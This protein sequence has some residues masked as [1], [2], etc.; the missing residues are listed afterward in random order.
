MHLAPIKGGGHG[1]LVP[2]VGELASLTSCTAVSTLLLMLT[3]P[4]ALGPGPLPSRKETVSPSL[5]LALSSGSCP[6]F[7][8]L[9]HSSLLNP[10]SHL[11]SDLK[12]PLWGL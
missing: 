1:P 3:S 9:P 11:G 12:T 8:P 10:L 4:E 5:D 7:N 2:L 6:S